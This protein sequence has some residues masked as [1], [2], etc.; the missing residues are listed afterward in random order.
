ALGWS[1]SGRSI[2]WHRRSGC[3]LSGR[4][5]PLERSFPAEELD[6]LEKPGRHLRAR[7]GDADRLESLTRLQSEPVEDAAERS[8]DRLRSEGLHVGER[9]A[10][11][12]DDCSAVAVPVEV[13]LDVVEEEAREAREVAELRDLLLH[14]RRRLPDEL[15][16]PVVAL[17]AEIQD[18]LVRELVGLQRAQVDAVHPVELRVV[19]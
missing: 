11:G 1:A 17:L 16:V 4:T 15:R 10:R 5:E 8:L 14:E 12:S 18:Q 2:R 6:A 19:E 9:V 3:L 13:R 7:H